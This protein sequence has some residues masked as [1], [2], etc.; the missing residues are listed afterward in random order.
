MQDSGRN[1]TYQLTHQLGAAIVEGQYAIDKG[2]P[3]EAELSLQFNIS[4][5]VTREA[6]KMLTAKGYS[7]ATEQSVEYV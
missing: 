1:L 2:F 5:S 4:R 7:G 6:V 3:T